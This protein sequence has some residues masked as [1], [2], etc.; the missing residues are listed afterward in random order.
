MLRVGQ[1]YDVHQLV[2]GRPLIIGGVHIPYEKGLLGHSDADVLLHAVTD[3]CLGAVGLGDI[4][5]YFPDNDDAYKNADSAV[6][7]K[8]V[9]EMIKDKGY[10][11][12]NIDAT[13]IAQKPKMAPYIELMKTNIA[14]ILE[15]ER[16]QINVKATT[17]EKL[18][19]TGREEGIASLAVVL[20]EKV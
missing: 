8:N 9:W 14:S 4:G 3:A 10:Q 15:A 11:L 5:S 16:E 13:I 2:A 20:L 7:L 17:T 19:F 6:L 1:G 12:V 18:G